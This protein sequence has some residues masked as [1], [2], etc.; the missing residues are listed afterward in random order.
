MSFYLLFA[1]EL[2]EWLLHHVKLFRFISHVMSNAF[3]DN[4]VHTTSAILQLY[5]ICVV[6]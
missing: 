5:N 2:L 1:K 4:S 6:Q 3:L